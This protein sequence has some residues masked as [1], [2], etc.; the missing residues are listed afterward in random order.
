MVD[1]FRVW[2]HEGVVVGAEEVQVQYARIGAAFPDG[3]VGLVNG[4]EHILTP[5]IIADGDEIPLPTH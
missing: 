3:H 4:S 2:S 1:L 5:V